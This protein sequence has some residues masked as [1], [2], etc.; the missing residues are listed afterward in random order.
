[1]SGGS[2]SV[3]RPLLQ[4]RLED[5]VAGCEKGMVMALSF[6]TPLERRRAE[7]LL[8]QRGAWE[9]AWFWGGYEDAE[10]A[11]LFLLP[12]YLL[13]CLSG[14]LHQCRAEELCALLEEWI[15]EEV[16][17]LRIT[18]SK[19]RTLTHRDYL[20]AILHL[21]LE[22]DALG[23]I[24]VQ[25]DHAAIL[26]CTPTV[27]TF[28][29]E[30]LQKAAN[31]AV[32]CSRCVLDESFTDGRSYRP[33]SDTVASARLDCVVAALIN[34]SREAAQTAIRAGRVEVEYE[35]VER[36]DL[37]L[38][39]PTVLSIRGHGRYILRAFDGTT[40]KGRLRLRADQLI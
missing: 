8:R 2:E 3:G 14:P 23:D 15:S 24:A 36:T 6:L 7:I 26:F 4:A 12:D 16:C 9:Q 28:L 22:R 13:T 40:A 35:V 11:T 32:R 33:I 1:M 39:P 37:V 17:A 19:F 38:T 20:G 29:T 31:D 27:A 18:G 5:A 10:R 34:A 25:N 30:H 21:G